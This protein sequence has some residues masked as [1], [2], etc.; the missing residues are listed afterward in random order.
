MKYK[1][2]LYEAPFNSIKSG[3]KTV[4]VR[5]NDDKRRQL[6]VG[7]SI[8][9]TKEASTLERLTVEIVALT[10]YPSF[11]AMYTHVPAQA[12]NTEGLTL[13]D[14]LAQTY[15]IYTP[16]QESQWGTLAITIK[17]ID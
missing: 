15:D 5:L 13:A 4:E 14:M 10:V 9:F 6:K 11:K 1:M 7:D 2:T 17:L 8:E 3:R 16:E 12:F